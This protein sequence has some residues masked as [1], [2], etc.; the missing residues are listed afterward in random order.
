MKKIISAV[1]VI[2][3]LFSMMM[4]MASAYDG[5]Y[6]EV[7]KPLGYNLV[8]YIMPTSTMVVT[9]FTENVDLWICPDTRSAPLYFSFRGTQINDVVIN[10]GVTIQAAGLQVTIYKSSN[11]K[12]FEIDNSSFYII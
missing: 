4:V 3:I 12:K 2:V 10:S 11:Y 6:N 7:N 8:G 9:G 5:Q 1:L